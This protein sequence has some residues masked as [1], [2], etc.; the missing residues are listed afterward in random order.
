VMQYD[1]KQYPVHFIGSVAHCYKEILQE[2][3]QTTGIQIGKILQSPMEGL[4][5]YHQ[6]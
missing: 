5:Q 4:I 3:A 1:Y 2:A 6:Q